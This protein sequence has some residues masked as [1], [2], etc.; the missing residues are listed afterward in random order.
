MSQLMNRLGWVRPTQLSA[1]RVIS[2]G[3]LQAGGSGKTPMVAKIAHEAFARGLKVCI[4]IRGYQSAWE[5]QGGHILPNQGPCDPRLCGDEA[6]LLQQL[7]PFAWIGVG[8]DRISCYR[9]LVEQLGRF[10]VV[11][12]D[13]GFQNWKIKKDVEVVLVT[14]ASR[15]QTVFRDFFKALKDADWVVFTKGGHW[16]Q[17]HPG[18]QQQLAGHVSVMRSVLT[19]DGRPFV[20]ES[21]VHA[22]A[23]LITGVAD[24]Q[25]VYRDLTAHG[26]A[27]MKH[28][29][30]RDHYAYQIG[31]IRQWL[32]QAKRDGAWVCV[33][34]K[35]AVKWRVLGVDR[36]E[37]KVLELELQSTEGEIAWSNVL[38][39]K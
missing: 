29:C 17:L 2:I 7:C 27:V 6:A 14:A 34:G 25:S 10:D 11:L 22:R 16:S 12:L 4:L 30:L 18:L 32:A 33:T 36:S 31:E 38:W 26:V 24:P 3:N 8:A 5:I 39:K 37:F 15:Q 35:D 13:D 9:S 23:W 28:V 19:L 20:N 21:T 1:G